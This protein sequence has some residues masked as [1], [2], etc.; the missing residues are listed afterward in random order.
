MSDYFFIGANEKGH[1]KNNMGGI[2]IKK[3]FKIKKSTV[4][5]I[6]FFTLLFSIVSIM[7]IFNEDSGSIG[8]WLNGVLSDSFGAT[9]FILP[10]ILG[11]HSAFMLK[12]KNPKFYS[13]L[14]Y[15]L[16][17]LFSVQGVLSIAGFDGGSIGYMID[18]ALGEILGSYMSVI[19]LFM[20]VFFFVAKLM[21]IYLTD[22]K[23]LI[24]GNMFEEDKV[25]AGKDNDSKQFRFPY[26]TGTPESKDTGINFGK[27]YPQSSFAKVCKSPEFLN[28]AKLNI[29]IGTDE[30][31]NMIYENI[32]SFP[33]AIVGGISGGG[34][35][36]FINNIICSLIM[37]N[38]PHELKFVLI[39]LKDGVEFAFY[40]NIQHLLFPIIEDIEGVSDAL[41]FID[42]EARKRN[43]TF[44]ENEVRNIEEYN[45]KDGFQMS[46]I[47]VI[48]DEMADITGKKH[49][50]IIEL[51]EK[52]IRKSRSCGIHFI[53]SIL[54]PLSDKTGSD[55]KATIATRIALKT[56]SQ[57]SS[58]VILD[59]T[60]AEKLM[61]K[62]DML[63]K[64]IHSPMYR[65]QGLS[66]TDS[67]ILGLVDVV[68]R[69]DDFIFAD[70]LETPSIKHNLAEKGNVIYL[71]NEPKDKISAEAEEVIKNAI[72][73]GSISITK[74]QNWLKKQFYGAR[75]IYTEIDNLGLIIHPEKESSNDPARLA[76]QSI[77]EWE[78]FKENLS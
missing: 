45:Q 41:N 12:A 23:N 55:I 8:S 59:E 63:I 13:K 61:S 51:L 48:V 17:T 40:R 6:S 25:F 9:K 22:M 27:R 1:A 76:L 34:K 67:N 4:E 19:L 60:G 58:K 11:I 35:S 15:A 20:L 47:I 18:S 28:G 57:H 46:R 70:Y 39:D 14:N 29:P 10:L 71:P 7:C 72:E 62:G 52:L 78:N 66:I 77:E 33:H 37:K 38:S 36:T 50:S 21:N 44:K 54:N 2:K 53:F 16:L 75:E 43:E 74:V 24:L 65:V 42:L 5:S 49:D 26:A 68:K 56:S 3:T 32:A 69:E 30:K 31:G 73:A 64:T